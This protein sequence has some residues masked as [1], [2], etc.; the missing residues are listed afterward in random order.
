M[1]MRRSLLAGEPLVPTP[2]PLDLNIPEID[3]IEFVRQR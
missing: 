1:G 3:G 2:D